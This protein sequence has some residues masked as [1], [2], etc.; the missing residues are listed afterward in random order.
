MKT[1][2]GII[3]S[4]ILANWGSHLYAEDIVV[5]RNIRA[6]HLISASDIQTPQSTNA[7]RR[8]T[9]M[10]GKEAARTLYKGQAVS[11]GDVRSPTLVTRNSIVA[12]TFTKGSMTIDAEG[13]ALED[14]SIGDRIRVMNLGSKRVTTM[15]VSGPES[16]KVKS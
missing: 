10:V 13:R 14:G 3:A 16:V 1:Y 4:T 7:L 9:M 8:A 12:M 6:G 15:T 5:N 11:D 2:V